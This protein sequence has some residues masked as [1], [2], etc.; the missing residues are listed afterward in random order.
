VRRQAAGASRDYF[1]RVRRQA[2]ARLAPA[3]AR[4]IDYPPL[5]V[6]PAFVSPA[7]RADRASILTRPLL[8]VP[9]GTQ[10]SHLIRR[11]RMGRRLYVGNLPYSTGES[12][13]Q[14]L[15]G[16][17]G[18]VESVRVMRDAATGRAR[19]FAFVE[20]GTDE[21]AQ[22][23]AS[24]FNGYQLGGRG[25]TVNEARPKPEGGFG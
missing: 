17:V 6:S 14:E 25:L 5:V 23:A 21:E 15:F 16:R 4:L 22:R 10:D 8:H 18:K 13:L 7:P 11:S 24:E 20:M 3:T 9:L 19:G 12:E 2:A 1:T